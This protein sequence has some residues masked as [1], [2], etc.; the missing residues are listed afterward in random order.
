MNRLLG[1]ACLVVA[2]ACAA[3]SVP[4]AGGGEMLFDGTSLDG[5]HPL[6]FGAEDTVRLEAGQLLL[7]FG[8]P[9][10]GVV[11]GGDVPR[12]NYELIVTAARLAG[13]DLFLGLTFPVGEE[14][15]TCVLGGWGGALCGLSCVDGEDASE[16]TTR[17]YRGFEPGVAVTLR[18]RV[19]AADVAAWVDGD[20]LFRQPRA[21]HELSV[22]T[23]V[24]DTR[25]LGIVAW[26]TRAAIF[27]IALRRLD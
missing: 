3:P 20:L 10:T 8:S 6:T 9:L 25:P 15:A 4:V 2:T 11:Y 21:G 1:P 27:S 13:T 5:W 18:L 19:S 7:D 16:N 23:D 22:R 17:S 24:L 26:N 12:D 14:H